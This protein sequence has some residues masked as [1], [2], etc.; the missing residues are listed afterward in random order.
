MWADRLRLLRPARRIALYLAMAEEIS[1]EPLLIRAKRRGCHTFLPRITDTRR[2]RM[3]FV[4]SRGAWR[5]G[6]WGVLEPATM[7][8]IAVRDLQVIFLPLVGFD[9]RGNRMG[10]GKGFYD[11][12]VAFR[13]LH[14]NIR[15]PLL[16]GLAFEC[17]QVDELPARS[18]DVPLD[19]LITER[20]PRRFG[21]ASTTGE[22]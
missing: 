5:R 20:G 8:R 11:R 4:D 15:R 9:A 7:H 10:M 18:H 6:R 12:A 3:V 17:Q 14:R 16:V 2:N 22:P 21:K 19:L 1:T 13:L